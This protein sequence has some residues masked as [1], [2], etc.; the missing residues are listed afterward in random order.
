MTCYWAESVHVLHMQGL[1]NRSTNPKG[2]PE[3]SSPPKNLS[4][5]INSVIRYVAQSWGQNKVDDKEWVRGKWD[6]PL[7]C[8]RESWDSYWGLCAHLKF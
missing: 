4:N 2:P 3:G 7:M 8:Y 5:H 6:F 1:G